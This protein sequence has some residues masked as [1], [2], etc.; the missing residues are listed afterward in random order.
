MLVSTAIPAAGSRG[1]DTAS[2]SESCVPMLSRFSSSHSSSADP[3]SFAPLSRISRF[4]PALCCENTL[5]GVA[6]T[7][8]FCSSAWC[9]VCS[10]PL[11]APASITSVARAKPEMIRFRRGK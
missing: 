4:V 10:A 3:T 11:V 5:P 2:P 7:S 9:A 6:N 8:R 1:G